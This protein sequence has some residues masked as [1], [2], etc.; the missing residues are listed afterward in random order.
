[1]TTY[2][3]N[4]IFVGIFDA[5]E[6]PKRIE[7]E[8]KRAKKMMAIAQDR[9]DP[10]PVLLLLNRGNVSF[11]LSPFNTHLNGYIVIQNAIEVT[12]FVV[13]S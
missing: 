8:S 9:I 7:G 10:L 6:T 11:V 1:M 12:S 3:R 5:K 4:G 13:H 2:A